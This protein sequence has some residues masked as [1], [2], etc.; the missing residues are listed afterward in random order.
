MMTD[1]TEN[2][3]AVGEASIA[4]VWQTGP[5]RG[6]IELSGG[7]VAAMRIAAHTGHVQTF[8]DDAPVFGA[9]LANAAALS[10]HRLRADVA[11]AASVAARA[12]AAVLV[13]PLTE[14]ELETLQLLPSHL[15]Y[16]GMAETLFV[17]PN[18]IKANLKSI[19]L[20]LGAEKRSEAVESARALGFID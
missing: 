8:L 18:T 9:L 11:I 20:K 3:G 16:K 2:P 1:R 17:S 7:G 15:T 12:S 5:G 4:I 10:G 13:E 6:D 14:R 19:Y